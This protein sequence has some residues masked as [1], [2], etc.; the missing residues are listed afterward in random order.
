MTVS[1]LISGQTLAVFDASGR[2]VESCEAAEGETV[3]SLP[4]VHSGL[5]VLL[6]DGQ[7]AVTFTVIR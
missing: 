7:P 1:G 4:G 3:L 5:H 2:L 6:V